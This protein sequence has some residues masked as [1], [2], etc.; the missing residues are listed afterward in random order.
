MANNSRAVEGAAEAS[1]P[2]QATRY[3]KTSWF[4]RLFFGYVNP[5]L[6]RAAKSPLEEQDVEWLVPPSDTAEQLGGECITT[7]RGDRG[8]EAACICV[9]AG[10][11]F[12]CR[13]RWVLNVT[14][15]QTHGG[16]QLRQPHAF[17]PHHLSP[18]YAAE[19]E[20]MYEKVKV[21]TCGWQRA[22]RRAGWLA[23]GAN[24]PGLCEGAA[25]LAC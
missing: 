16:T 20:R 2:F 3:D 22:G 11:G 19:F 25:A 10:G 8:G 4:A 1:E 9:S 7:R 21:G 5:L 6:S 12:W 23:R 14:N 24:G 15:G 13:G 18:S 17:H